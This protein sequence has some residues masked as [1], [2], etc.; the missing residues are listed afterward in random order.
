MNSSTGSGVGFLVGVV[1]N[2]FVSSSLS[3]SS[4]S[5][6]SVVLV[7]VIVSVSVVGFLTETGR[8]VAVAVATE[9]TVVF[10]DV[11]FSVGDSVSLPGIILFDCSSSIA[12]LALVLASLLL[13][14]LDVI[15]AY[16][17]TPMA[18]NNMI[19]KTIIIIVIN[20]NLLLRGCGTIFL[21]L[22]LLL[23]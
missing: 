17:I 10:A 5:L 19:D 13:L 9:S 3:P 8:K 14:F 18:D 15:V 23:W 11:I 12:A 21:F 1:V 16:A 7:L 22:L 20:N 4:L 6:S 2:L